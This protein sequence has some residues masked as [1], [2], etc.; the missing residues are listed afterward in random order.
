[1]T[2][3]DFTFYSR[4]EY[5][6]DLAKRVT[7]L[8][9]GDRVALATMT[10]RP[11]EPLVCD[12][13]EALRAAAKRGVDVLLAVDAHN[14]LIND[15]QQLG[16]LFF[17]RNIP[18]RMPKNFRTKLE[19]LEL[20]AAH[21]GH[22]T[23]T[24][25]PKRAFTSPFS[26]RSHI[27]FAI[28]NNRVYIGCC[29]LSHAEQLDIMTAW[30][31]Q[32][33]ADWL[34]DF[35]K[36]MLSYDG[37]SFMQGTDIEVAVDD[38]SVILVDAGVRKQSIIFENALKLIDGAE[39]ELL[40]TCQYFPGGVTAQHLL[41]AHRRGVKVTIMYSPPHVHGHEALAHHLHIQRERLR[42]PKEFFV[43]QLP[44][45][46]PRLHAKVLASE[47]AVIIGSHNFVSQG[48]TFGTAEIALLRQDPAFARNAVQALR[49]QLDE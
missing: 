13:V 37:T 3:D 8:K 40:I 36:Q 4:A 17:H 31:D 7:K 21:G 30:I 45:S 19:A 44:K 23:I 41:A 47:K 39:K 35:A 48:V 28:I 49:R 16:P 43:G 10:F 33:T 15:R 20:L 32:K 34:Y 1:M 46:L 26:G 25:I 24:N 38:K 6:K 11:D 29:N 14:F 9:P 27:K 5:F 12:L 22:Y 18:E 42:L 2:N